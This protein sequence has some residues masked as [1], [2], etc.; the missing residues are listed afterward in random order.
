MDALSR[1]APGIASFINQQPAET[2]DIGD[3]SIKTQNLLQSLAHS[4]PS[5]TDFSSHAPHADLPLPLP[6]EIA[7]SHQRATD[8]GIFDTFSFLGLARLFNLAEQGPSA[9]MDKQ[10]NALEF[11]GMQERASNTSIENNAPDN[12][13]LWLG[14]LDTQW[15]FKDIG[16]ALP[17]PQESCLSGNTDPTSSYMPTN[18]TL[19]CHTNLESDLFDENSQSPSWDI[20]TAVASQSPNTT[21]MS[22]TFTHSA[23][24]D[25]I[26]FLS[27]K[28]NSNAQAAAAGSPA[29]SNT[30]SCP[31]TVHLDASAA[32]AKCSR[33]AHHTCQKLSSAASSSGR[34]SPEAQ[35]ALQQILHSIRNNPYPSDVLI[36]DIRVK[37]GLSSKQVRNWFALQRFRHM[38]RIEHQGTTSWRFRNEALQNT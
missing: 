12:K 34:F 27:K 23:H 26:P 22:T 3:A 36:E 35:K 8:N 18:T 5:L 32:S 24:A 25:P 38:V 15:P 33:D 7:S 6:V 10:H 14:M 21:P 4:E 11:L 13:F 28:D 1:R 2:F 16:T 20:V 37:F 17:S 19:Q 30:S 9:A 29:A 31:S